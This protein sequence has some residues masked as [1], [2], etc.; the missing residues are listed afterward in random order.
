[1]RADLEIICEWIEADSR[2]LDLGCGDG[3]LLHH[4]AEHRGVRGYGLDVD[5]GNIQACIRKGVPA[6]QANLDKGLFHFDDNSFDYVVMTEALQVMRRPDLMVEEM[7][8]IGRRCIVTFPNFGHWRCRLGLGFR[9]RMPVSQTLPDAWYD[10]PN[11]HLCTVA[12]FE[13]FCG[14]R[15][16][17]VLK[18]SVVDRHHRSTTGM[19]LFPN[20]MA[21]IALYMLCP[22]R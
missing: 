4:L 16:I 15:R 20:L 21:E 11:I 12:D 14:S 19:R 2:V 8:R 22:H 13:T 9:G 18:R 1:M 10:T 5:V 6:I 7:L 17:Q 3:E